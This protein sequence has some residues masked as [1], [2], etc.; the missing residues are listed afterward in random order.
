MNLS[1]KRKLTAIITLSVMLVAVVATACILTVPN[2]Y[3]GGEDVVPTNTANDYGIQAPVYDKNTAAMAYCDL[4]NGDKGSIKVLFPKTIYLDKTESLDEVGYNIYY[5]VY[6][7]TSNTANINSSSVIAFDTIFGYYAPK[8]S[9]PDTDTYPNSTTMTQIFSGYDVEREK[10]VGGKIQGG[11]DNKNE[12]WNSSNSGIDI[13]AYRDYTVVKNTLKGTIADPNKDYIADNNDVNN[14]T[15]T[16]PVGYLL[17]YTKYRTTTTGRW[18][19]IDKT[20]KYGFEANGGTAAG[21]DFYSDMKAIG[22]SS[23]TGV[24]YMSNVEINIH[25][26]DK[27]D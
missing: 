9:V 21:T 5:N 16:C 1:K 17:G 8:A 18:H 24:G 12:L 10:L 15:F 26:Y 3:R 22:L 11:I 20:M 27:Y 14:A 19:S 6:S 7:E 25:I 13:V 2:L 23:A 4:T